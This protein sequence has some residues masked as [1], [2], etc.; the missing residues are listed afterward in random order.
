MS[1]AQWYSSFRTKKHHV[2]L[3]SL[4]LYSQVASV[5]RVN[6]TVAGIGMH[7]LVS[8]SA[9]CTMLCLIAY[10]QARAHELPNSPP[11]LHSKLATPWP[12]LSCSC[13]VPALA[14]P[15]LPAPALPT[16]HPRIDAAASVLSATSA[17][18]SLELRHQHQQ[19]QQPVNVAASS[20]TM[21][22]PSGGTHADGGGSPGGGI[23]RCQDCWLLAM[24]GCAHH[25]CRSCC[26]GRGFVCPA[27]VPASS[28]PSSER[29]Q[30][31]TAPA[32]TV[33]AAPS[34]KRPL[35]AVATPT[36]TTS[37]SGTCLML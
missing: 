30:V 27:H 35:D 29:Q 36:T 37:S 26:W 14:A 15:S 4:V 19:Q 8:G 28:S 16:M 12:R 7:A 10:A 11:W 6:R 17:E 2:Q 32:A 13:L 31:L 21:P 24:A 9:Y 18:G 34:R 5:A 20:S 22:P 33:A 23:I 1:S 3:A 25:R